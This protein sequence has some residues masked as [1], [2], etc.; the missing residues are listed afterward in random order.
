VWV[1]VGF[2]P[3]L[4]AGLAFI[5]VGLLW[6]SQVSTGGSFLA[7]ILGPSLLA[8][9]GLGFVATLLLVRGRDSRTHVEMSQAE[10]PA[11]A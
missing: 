3:V 11:S 8:A 2:K 6:F 7:D 4:A 10:V 1:K 5:A 9:I